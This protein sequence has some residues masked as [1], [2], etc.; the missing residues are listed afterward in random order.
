M[1][2]LRQWLLWGLLLASCVAAFGCNTLRGAGEDL[3]RAGEAIQDA[4][5]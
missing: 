1:R 3:E 2:C 4:I 5:D